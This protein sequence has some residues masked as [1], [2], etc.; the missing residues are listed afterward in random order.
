MPSSLLLWSTLSSNKKISLRA[1]CPE[2]LGPATWLS[3]HNSAPQRVLRATGQIGTDIAAT[4]NN[5][6][7]PTLR[8]RCPLCRDDKEG[9]V[10]LGYPCPALLLRTP[11]A[12]QTAQRGQGLSGSL[13]VQDIRK[14]CTTWKILCLPY[15]PVELYLKS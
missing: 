7:F 1:V 10:C 2:Y 9:R 14:S 13:L 4:C 6:L 15:K 3:K 5:Q 11:S 8:Q 12:G